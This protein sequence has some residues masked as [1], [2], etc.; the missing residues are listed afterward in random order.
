MNNYKESLV[1]KFL[2]NKWHRTESSLLKDEK[3]VVT[4]D[5]RSF[6][7]TESSFKKKKEPT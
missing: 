1:K 3:R 6:K 7:N 4:T 5:V 2:D